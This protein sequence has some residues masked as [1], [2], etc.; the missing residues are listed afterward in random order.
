MLRR[1]RAPIRLQSSGALFDPVAMH[2]DTL[3]VLPTPLDELGGGTVDIV[4]GDGSM[5]RTFT[6]DSIGMATDY[7]GKYGKY[8]KKKP[9]ALDFKF[10]LTVPGPAPDDDI[11]VGERDHLFLDLKKVSEGTISF[12]GDTTGRLPINCLLWWEAL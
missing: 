6:L 4:V 7:K 12:P 3:F 9:W 10:T 8:E 1:Q 11:F 2:E 5:H